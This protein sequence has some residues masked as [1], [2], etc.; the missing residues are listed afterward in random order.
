MT[1]QPQDPGSSESYSSGLGRSEPEPFAPERSE[2][3]TEVTPPPVTRP[4]P[5]PPVPPASVPPFDPPPVGT[6]GYSSQPTS[7]SSGVDYSPAGS[8]QSLTDRPEV[9]IA[10]TFVGGL[11]VAAILKRLAR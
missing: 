9:L 5:V 10:G 11:L 4:D 6:S 8:S 3:G 1:E 2:P 7:A